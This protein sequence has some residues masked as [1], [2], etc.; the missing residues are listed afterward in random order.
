MIITNILIKYF[1]LLDTESWN[2][3]F[4]IIYVYQTHYIIIKNFRM[5]FCSRSSVNDLILYTLI[6]K[7]KLQWNDIFPKSFSGGGGWGKAHA[8]RNIEKKSTFEPYPLSKGRIL[9]SLYL[10]L[11]SANELQATF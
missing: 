3:L 5:V 7:L 2:L 4:H 6:Q 10:Y 9:S 8:S 1:S 11:G